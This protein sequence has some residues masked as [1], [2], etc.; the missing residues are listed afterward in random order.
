LVFSL[1]TASMSSRRYPCAGVPGQFDASVDVTD[2]LHASAFGRSRI[3][4]ELNGLQSYREC[5]GNKC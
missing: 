1:I 4:S 5:F 2:A 3:L